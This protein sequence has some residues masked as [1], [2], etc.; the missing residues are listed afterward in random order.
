MY[1]CQYK[2]T[3]SLVFHCVLNRVIL[4]L[5]ELTHQYHVSFQVMASISLVMQSA[6]LTVLLHNS[7]FAL[8]HKNS[9]LWT[10]R[11]SPES[12]LEN[13]R[14]MVTGD[15]F[16]DGEHSFVLYPCRNSFPFRWRTTSL[17]MCWCLSKEGVSGSLDRKTDTLH[18]SLFS[19]FN[20]WIFFFWGFVKDVYHEKCKMWMSWHDRIRAALCYQLNAC[21]YHLMN[22]ILS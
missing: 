19:R 4:I 3:E 11:K 16:C 6:T 2:I 1:A 20:S 17:L 7:H 13:M 8:F 21:Q 15:T 10:P 5:S 14:A 18:G 12:N 22:W 9:V